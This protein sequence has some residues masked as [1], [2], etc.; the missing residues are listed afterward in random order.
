MLPFAIHNIHLDDRLVCDVELI[1]IGA[2]FP[3]TGFMT[4][5]EYQGVLNQ[6][7]LPSG[8]LFPLPIVLPM[9]INGMSNLDS[10]ILSI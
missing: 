7:E 10:S 3:L 5:E 8:E 9:M 1:L 2:L 6:M 4:Q